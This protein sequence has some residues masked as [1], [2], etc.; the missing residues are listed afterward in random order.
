F[1]YGEHPRLPFDLHHLGGPV[2]DHVGRRPVRRLADKNT[3]ERRRSLQPCS[4]V[5]DVAGCHRLSLARTGVEAD[6]RLTG[7]DTDAPLELGGLLLAG[8]V[9]NRERRA[10]R[11]LGVVLVR[12]GRAEERHHRI[13]D[14]LL[15]RPAVALELAPY[16]RVVR[17]EKRADV[18]WIEAFCP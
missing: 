7:V 14:E 8:P 11:T 16:M 1:A 4:G 12:D 18:L 2:V 15:H 3:V 17:I 5:D 6:Q 13:A 9:A 10:H